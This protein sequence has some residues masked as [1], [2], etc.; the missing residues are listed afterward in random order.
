MSIHKSLVA[1]GKLKRHRNVLSR[2]ER[3]DRLAKED[4]WQEGMSI[5]G[6]PKVKHI[7]H[8]AKA[9]V[10]KEAAPTEEAVP[11]PET[12][13]QPEQEAISKEKTSSKR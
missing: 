11:I 8:K 13:T 10:K 3:I 4:K 6:L 1:R 7:M 2:A 5:F 9:K 12:P